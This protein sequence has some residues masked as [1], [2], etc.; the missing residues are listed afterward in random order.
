[1]KGF[2]RALALERAFELAW[3][4]AVP[5]VRA[6]PFETSVYNLWSKTGASPALLINTTEVETGARVVIAPFRQMVDPIHKQQAD[7]EIH[8][9][10][11]LLDEAPNLDLRLSTAVGISARFP[12]ISPAAWYIENR[13]KNIYQKRRLVDG[14]YYDNSGI[15]TALD[16]IKTML[17]ESQKQGVTIDIKLIVLTGVPTEGAP[18]YAFGEIFSPFDTL[19]S[20][21]EEHGRRLEQLAQQ[22]M[23][24]Q[25]NGASLSI[26][27]ARLD[28]EQLKLPLGWQ[29]SID[30][31]KAIEENV[32]T[33]NCEEVSSANANQLKQ[34]GVQ[35]SSCTMGQIYSDL[36]IRTQK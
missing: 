19:L 12:Y 32:G 33:P 29:L 28:A 16:V 20:T 2:D 1:L 5:S 18:S 7:E 6:N 8:A 31:R 23:R 24:G 10:N 30:S 9:F 4:D 15:A 3:A 21:R 34:T 14:G 25:Q 11:S 17:S 13:A 22:T 27:Y 36:N 26:L 35:I